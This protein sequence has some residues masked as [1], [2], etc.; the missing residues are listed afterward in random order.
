MTSESELLNIKCP[1]CLAPSVLPRITKCGHIFCFVCTLQYLGPEFRKYFFYL[2]YPINYLTLTLSNIY[3]YIY[4]YKFRKCP[5]CSDKISRDDLKSV[6]YTSV[7]EPE[8]NKLFTFH[9]VRC[10]KVNSIVMLFYY[11]LLSLIDFCW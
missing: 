2:Y 1:I 8:L 10:E 7:Q 5:I 11:F 3:I 9:L 4:I 6:K